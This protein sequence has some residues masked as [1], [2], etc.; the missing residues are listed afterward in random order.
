MPNRI[1]IACCVIFCALEL[2]PL[3]PLRARRITQLLC[4]LLLFSVSCASDDTAFT[5]AS[6]RGLAGA[7]SSVAVAGQPSTGG[8][9]S[10]FTATETG[11]LLS[12]G[13]SPTSVDSRTAIGGKSGETASSATGGQTKA[14]ASSSTVVGGTMSASGD[15]GAPSTLYP[16]TGSAGLAVAGSSATGGTPSSVAGSAGLPSSGG[17]LSSSITS[18]GSPA[19]AGHSASGGASSIVRVVFVALAGSPSDSTIDTTVELENLTDS[20]LDLTGMT[21]RYWATLDSATGGLVGTC[22][23]G[24]CGSSVVAT[25]AVTPARSGADYFI[26]YRFGGATIVAR[27]KLEFDFQAHGSS[28]TALAELNDYSYP[29]DAK[30][31]EVLDRITV[32][33]A[34]KLIW[35]NEP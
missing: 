24:P 20:I 12:Q 14:M 3:K 19:A 15:A 26:D 30:P 7:D 33:Q 35:G 6:S 29:G 17:T 34:G 25:G 11:G 1:R 9:E 16:N 22:P 13:G 18:A 28:W 21:V 8:T 31:G 10:N 23:F 5:S 4:M 32:Y 27:G 2:F